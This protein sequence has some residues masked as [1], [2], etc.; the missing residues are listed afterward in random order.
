M[1]KVLDTNN[2]PLFFT[3]TVQQQLLPMKM[4]LMTFHIWINLLLAEIVR[5]NLFD[6]RLLRLRWF[7]M[8]ELNISPVYLKLFISLMFFNCGIAK[9][10]LHLIKTSTCQFVLQLINVVYYFVFIQGNQKNNDD[11]ECVLLLQ[12]GSWNK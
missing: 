10:F 11:N 5:Y 9:Q 4:A 6:K 7:L 8:F 3:A 1:E 2:V 12:I